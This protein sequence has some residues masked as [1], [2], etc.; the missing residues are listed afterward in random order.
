MVWTRFTWHGLGPVVGFS[1]HGRGTFGIRK[2]RGIF[3]LGEQLLP[4]KEGL[5]SKE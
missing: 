5:W 3:C 2:M 1:E 4:S